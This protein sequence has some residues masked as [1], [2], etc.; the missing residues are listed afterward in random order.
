MTH[1]PIIANSLP[2][3][4][5]FLLMKILD[6]FGYQ[7]NVPQPGKPQALNYKEVKAALAQQT[8]SDLGE[9][10]IAVSPFAPCHIN[11]STFSGWLEAVPAG[12]YIPAHIPWT[13][14]LAPMLT[15]LNCRH[16]LIM[17]DIQAI[18]AELVYGNEIMPRFLKADIESLSLT[19]RQDFFLTGG[20]AAHAGVVVKSIAEIYRSMQA[21]RNDPSCLVVDFEELLSADK[22][23]PVLNRMADYLEIRIDNMD[24]HLAAINS[25]CATCLEPR[26]IH[27]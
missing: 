17:R 23:Q 20:Y 27:D 2:L 18:L 9:N 21:W 10:P 25:F 14:A 19:E 16:I 22:Q 15:A 6:S 26:S 5:P 1:Y 4:G 13:A 7:K 8:S 24:G 12:S 11:Q 3:G